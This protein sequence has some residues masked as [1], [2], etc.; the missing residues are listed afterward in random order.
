[1][2]LPLGD[3]K[4]VKQLLVSDSGHSWFEHDIINRKAAEKNSRARCVDV[5]LHTAKFTFNI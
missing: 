4:L 1:M 3:A 2:F 5:H